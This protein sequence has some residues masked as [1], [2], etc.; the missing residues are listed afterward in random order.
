[1]KSNIGRIHSQGSQLN[2]EAWL[3][4]VVAALRPRFRKAGL[5]LPRKIR[6]S[7]GWPSSGGWAKSANSVEA[8]CFSRK[9]SYS[10]HVEIFISPFLCNDVEVAAALTHEL[11]HGRQEVPNHKPTWQKE[12]RMIGLRVGKPAWNTT[13]TP[14]FRAELVKLV[15]RIGPYP[16]QGM[17]L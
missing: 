6:A 15:Q 8:E 9:H 5:T 16:H 4:A 1:M 2:R 7:C 10:G 17:H 12:A 11:L 14:E 13:P 3:M